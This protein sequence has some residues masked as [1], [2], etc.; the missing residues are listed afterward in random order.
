MHLVRAAKVS[1]ARTATSAAAWVTV[2]IKVG[3]LALALKEKK[4]VEAGALL[5]S[6]VAAGGTIHFTLNHFL[7]YGCPTSSLVAN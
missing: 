2:A 3:T 1:L 7:T 4:V 6:P 5:I